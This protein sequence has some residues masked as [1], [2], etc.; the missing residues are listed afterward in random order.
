MALPSGTT[1]DGAWGPTEMPGIE[2][3]LVACKTN[4]HPSVKSLC[5]Q[6]DINL[7]NIWPHV[8][9]SLHYMQK[10]NHLQFLVF[11]YK[12]FDITTLE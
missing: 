9:D 6:Q 7:M 2:P 11:L 10:Y 5:P 8:L 12:D 1:P 4:T 3:G